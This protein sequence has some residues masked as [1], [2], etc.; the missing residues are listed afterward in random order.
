MLTKKPKIKHLKDVWKP[1]ALKILGENPT[2]WGLYH[3]K[4]SNFYIYRKVWLKDFYTGK[5]GWKVEEV[6]S[7]EK[8]RQIIDEF[9]LAAKQSVI[10][11]EAV[12]LGNNVGKICARR[13][14]RSHKN[15][16]INWGRTNKQ[17]MVISPITGKERRK[18]VY[19]TDDDY[20]RIGFHKMGMIP[21]EMA[22]EFSPAENNK[23]GTGFKQEFTK[24]LQTNILLKYRYLYYPLQ[25]EEKPVK[26]LA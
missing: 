12:N 7:Y 15:K 18:F 19:H 20:C 3:N 25:T 21:N 11:G 16:Q 23:C 9:F 24:A 10:Q 8:F 26:A 5:E 17:E 14:E 2:W 22:Y 13:V 1:Y 4:I 6:F